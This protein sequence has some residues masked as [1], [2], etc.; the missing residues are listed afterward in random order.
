MTNKDI[1]GLFLDTYRVNNMSENTIKAYD[2]ILNE[3]DGVIEKEFSELSLLDIDAYKAYKKTMSINTQN[4]A[5]MCLKVFIKFLYKR[6]VIKENFSQDVEKIQSAK[7]VQN[8][9]YMTEEHQRQLIDY[10]KG[11]KN[12]WL[13]MRNR[14]MFLLYISTGMRKSELLGIKISDIQTTDNKDIIILIKGKGNKER[15]IWLN[16]TVHDYLLSYI[17]DYAIDEKDYLFTTSR[18]NTIDPANVNKLLNNI[19]AEIGLPH[20]SVH[21]LR[22]ACASMMFESGAT[23]EDVQLALGH[24]NISTTENIY[25]HYTPN[26]QMEGFKKNKLF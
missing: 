21:D 5:I 12:T 6:K 23:K 14:L 13:N 20:Y 18:G 16:E 17:S 3:F 4:Q 26:R 19:L 7:R 2:R 24:A 8:R 22:H 15:Y 11:L 25:I 1:I 9:K 10:L